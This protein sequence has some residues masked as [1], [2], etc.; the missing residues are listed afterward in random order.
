MCYLS[1]KRPASHFKPLS[2]TPTTIPPIY[3]NNVAVAVLYMNPT[4]FQRRKYDCMV[5]IVDRHSGWIIAFPESRVGLT[6]ER[7]ARQTIFH[8]W[9]LFGIPR[10]VVSDKGPQI[11][12]A[13]W[14]TICSYMGV[15]NAFCHAG[16]HQGNG[17]A[18]VAGKLLKQF[19][20]M[21][22][23][24]HKGLNWVETLPLALKHLCNAPR[25][26]GYSPY[27]IILGRDPLLPGL[28]MPP[29]F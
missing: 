20:R 19:M 15:Q 10:I 24:V 29:S 14:K 13:F 4:N 26:S 1:T 7:V 9:D 2:P 21:V 22:Q 23:N 27:Q 25:Q 11:A 17:R 16:Y 12:A 5:I 6:A 28:P 3:M 18:E 8:H